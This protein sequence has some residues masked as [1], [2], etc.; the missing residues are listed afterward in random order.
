MAGQI[1]GFASGGWKRNVVVGLGYVLGSLLLV[2]LLR[3]LVGLL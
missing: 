2:G 3:L 1:P